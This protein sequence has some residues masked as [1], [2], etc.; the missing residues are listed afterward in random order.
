MIINII[1]SMPDIFAALNHGI[2]GHA[3]KNQIISINIIPLRNFSDRDDKRIDDRP[4]GGGPGMVLEAESVYRA[5]QAAGKSH[6]IELCPKGQR[7]TNSKVKNLAT[8]ENITL[9]CGRYEGIDHRVSSLIDEKVSIGDFVLSGGEIPALA[10]IDA[11]ARFQPGAITKASLDED[12]FANDLLDHNHFTRPDTWMG[13][14]VP[15]V[16]KSGN[17]KAI[18][19]YRLAQSIGQTWLNRPDLLINRKISQNELAMLIKFVQNH[20]RR[21]EDYD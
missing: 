2:L 19:D 3:I 13:K 20:D 14:A 16:L 21:G 6:V 18:A 7:L 8:I 9:V 12:S 15:E 5:L 10:L 4:Y 17:H 11:L 1:T